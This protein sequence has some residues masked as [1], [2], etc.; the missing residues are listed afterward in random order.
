M[1]VETYII[2]VNKFL[3]GVLNIACPQIFGHGEMNLRGK[4]LSKH[5]Y[6][7]GFV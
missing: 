1:C 6:L 5:L 2:K 7:T 3:K 4:L